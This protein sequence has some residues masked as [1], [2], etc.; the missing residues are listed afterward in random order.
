MTIR[1]FADRRSDDDEPPAEQHRAEGVDTELGKDVVCT[2]PQHVALVVGD[3]EGAPVDAGVVDHHV[4]RL[5]ADGLDEA[6]DRGLR[7][8][9]EG[10]DVVGQ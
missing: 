3:A 4:D 10:M 1:G 7:R 2:E 6:L 8:D 5:V 9:V